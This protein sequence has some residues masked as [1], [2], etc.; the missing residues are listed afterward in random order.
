[1]CTR[2]YAKKATLSPIITGL[3][4]AEWS[5]GKLSSFSDKQVLHGL[6]KSHNK[7]A[8]GSH[9]SFAFYYSDKAFHE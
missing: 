6:K 8:N 5:D 2:F 3:P 1:M 4:R 7:K 9:K